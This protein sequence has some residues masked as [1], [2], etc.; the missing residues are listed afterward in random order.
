M[1][2]V[3]EKMSSKRLLRTENDKDDNG[4]NLAK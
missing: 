2:G 3:Q 1:S 4:T